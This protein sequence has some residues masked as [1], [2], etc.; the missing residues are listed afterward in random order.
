[1]VI[2]YSF[3]Y[4]Y[5]RVNG[6]CSDLFLLHIQY[7]CTGMGNMDDVL[8]LG[9]KHVQTSTMGYQITVYQVISTNT[10]PID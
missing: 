4:V 10:N 1:M 9:I 3:L 5:Q 2:F 6:E 8:F 7:S